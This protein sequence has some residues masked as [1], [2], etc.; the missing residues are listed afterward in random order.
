MSFFSKLKVR[1]KLILLFVF[2]GVVPALVVVGA[3]VSRLDYFEKPYGEAVATAARDINM[4]IDRSL[5]ASYSDVQ[6]FALNGAAWNEKNWRLPDATQNPLVAAMNGYV[7]HYGIYTLTLLIDPEGHLLAVNTVDKA[8]KSI[9]TKPLY[10]KDFKQAPWFQTTLNKE[11][12]V[13]R[14]QLTG[15]VVS[16]PYRDE[17]VASIYGTDGLSISFSA[18]VHDHAGHLIGF[19]INIASFNMVEDLIV[20]N[21]KILTKQGLPDVEIMLLDQTGT[22][23]MQYDPQTAKTITYARDFKNVLNVNSVKLGNKASI[24]AVVDGKNGFMRAVSIRKKIEQFVGYN[25]SSGFSDFPGLNWSLFVR[26]PT[27]SALHAVRDTTHFMMLTLCITAVL[28]GLLGLLFGNLAAKPLQR[29]T[30]AIK[31]IADGQLDIDIA[32]TDKADEFG[33]VAR[34]V[35]VF[36]DNAREVARLKAEHERLAIEAEQKKRVALNNMAQTFEEQVGHI[37][38]GLSKEAGNLQ[39]DAKNLTELASVT[40]RQATTV[41]AATEEASTSVQTVAAA[42]EEL[43][44]SIAEINHQIAESSRVAETAVNEIKRTDETVSTLSEA[45][46]QIGDVTNLIQ[47]I[48]EQTNLLALNATIEAARGWRSG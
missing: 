6:T 37:V 26:M 2:F 25:H 27:E 48:A 17:T 1:T 19:W 22:V 15:T 24:A 21:Y 40:N 39:S 47:D 8:G 46:Q 18:P 38:A 12:L 31:S 41:A 33:D 45:A 5:F 28:A 13:G 3:F 14:N 43:S 9:D 16:S 23:L 4:M 34:A 44:A 29:T 10:E 42:T 32:Y 7:R 36:R 11:F 20:E 30:T 35:Q